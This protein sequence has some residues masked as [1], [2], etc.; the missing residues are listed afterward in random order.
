MKTQK[1]LMPILSG[2]L[3]FAIQGRGQNVFEMTFKGTATTTNDAGNIVSTKLSNKTLIQDAAT[4]RGITNAASLDA[5][6]VQGAGTD[7]NAMGD[8]VEVVT[9]TNGAPVYTNLQF[10]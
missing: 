4:E 6:Y 2:L 8:F 1:I 10:M 5:V 9:K 3:A 7:T